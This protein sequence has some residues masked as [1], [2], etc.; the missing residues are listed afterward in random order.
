MK[1]I[2]I[3]IISFLFF[4]ACSYNKNN[5]QQNHS[6]YGNEPV[7]VQNPS[8]QIGKSDISL[9]KIRVNILY[10]DKNA[11]V[12]ELTKYD[13]EIIFENDHMS[14]MTVLIP[15]SYKDEISQLPSVNHFEIDKEIKVNP[16]QVVSWDKEMIRMEEAISSNFTGNGVKIAVI[17]S[18]IA[19]HEDLEIAGGISFVDYTNSYEDDNGHGTHVA[20]IIGAKNNDRGVVGVAP[21]AQ[22]YAVKVLDYNGEG[23]VSNI[24]YGVR[25]AIDQGMDII[26]ISAGTKSDSYLLKSMID[27]AYK[28]NILVIVAAGNDGNETGSGD[29][30]DY[31]AKYNSAIAVG[32]IDKNRIRAPFSSTG[33]ALEIT[34]PGVNILS[35][36]LNNEYIQMS[37]TSMATPFIS[38]ISA[39]LME[40]NPNTSAENIRRLLQS[41]SIDLGAVGR[42]PLYGYGLGQAPYYFNDIY[43]SWARNEILDIYKRK[44]MQGVSTKNF[45]PNLPLTRAQ[46]AV[47]VQRIFNLNA[48]Q[49]HSFIDVRDD[50]WAVN[51]INAV[52]EAGYMNGIGDGK[53]DPNS[54]LTREQFAVILDR[55]LIKRG[56]LNDNN[57][58]PSPFRDVPNLHWSKNSIVRINQLGIIRGVTLTSF[59]PYDPLT[60]A[61]MAVMLSRGTQYLL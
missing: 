46:A 42:D 40:A 61:Q 33:H 45:A 60:R 17:D 30:M 26:N 55:I 13:S 21:N 8:K 44:W 48:I 28:K 14:L 3:F 34:A 27:E 24:A 51:E 4:T 38:G 36:Y 29:T 6:Q 32:A 10:N 5:V 41:G 12:G 7:K 56:I 50:F 20:G 57:P 2:F 18:G 37:G 52:V 59:S 43:T 47:I 1:K 16:V 23:Y 25:W 39:L 53:F 9:E 58:G 54:P 35:T 22:L 15:V 49:Q 31:P 11:L 19:P